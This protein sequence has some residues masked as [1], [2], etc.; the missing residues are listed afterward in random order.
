MAASNNALF[1][2]A[3]DDFLT[4]DLGWVSTGISV[5][6]V[7]NY[8]VFDANDVILG[9]VTSSGTLNTDADQSLTGRSA[10]GTGIA[11][12]SDALFTSVSDGA[13]TD[14]AILIYETGGSN[15]V[16]A[17]IGTGTNLPVQPNGGNITITWQNS[18]SR[19]FKL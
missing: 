6:L 10:D 19:I 14:H 7:R 9:D 12:A 11:D 17:H 3:R 16:I 13:G 2:A 18:G 15:R 8:N 5:A 4:G 1:D